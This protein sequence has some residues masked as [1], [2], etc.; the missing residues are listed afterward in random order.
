M[1]HVLYGRSKVRLDLEFWLSLS[2]T[3]V[4]SFVQ[5]QKV[6]LAAFF[7]VLP[8]PYMHHSCYQ[9]KASVMVT[10]D[11]FVDL[12]SSGDGLLRSCLRLFHVGA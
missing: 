11:A 2:E 7:Y 12:F 5:M 4:I 3:V 6:K 1:G 9:Q 8:Y 10:D